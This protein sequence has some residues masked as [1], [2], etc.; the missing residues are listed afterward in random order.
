MSDSIKKMSVRMLQ[1]QFS[2]ILAGIQKMRSQAAAAVNEKHLN[3][4]WFVGGLVSHKIKSNEWGAKVVS[5]LADYIRTQDPTLRGFSKRNIYN[6]VMLYDEYSS[7][8][9][10]NFVRSKLNPE[11][12]QLETAQLENIQKR[13]AINSSSLIVQSETAQLPAFPKFI[14]LT[15]FTNHVAILCNCKSYE[16]RL[17]YMLYANKERLCCDELKRSIANDTFTTL[18][19]SKKNLSKGMLKNYPQAG[20]TF[21]DELFLDFLN[22]PEKHSEN[23]LKKS[24]VEQ[25]KNFILELG[26]KEFLFVDMEYVLQVGASSYK[27]DLLFYHRGLQ[28]LVAIELKTTKFHPKDLGQLEFYLEAL[29]R[30]VRKSN[31]NPSIG[32]I[33]CPSADQ[34]VVEYAMNRSMSPTLIAEYKKKL[35]PQETVQ[36][37][38]GEYCASFEMGATQRKKVSTKRKNK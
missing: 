37:L 20:I 36:K 7:V 31:E 19:R 5:D 30:D 24:I 12:V 3:S 27:A 35:I 28:A 2:A 25:M 26:S 15:S 11:F 22:L 1:S 18:L 16:Q 32:M 14:G 8:D 17:F 29:D 23:K 4:V 9:F 10:L 33:L 38:L 6:M 34:V 13:D 21:K